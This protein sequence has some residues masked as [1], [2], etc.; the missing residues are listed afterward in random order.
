MKLFTLLLLLLACCSTRGTIPTSEEVDEQL[1]EKHKLYL[2]GSESFKDSSGFTFEHRGDSMLFSCLNGASGLEVEYWNAVLSD[3]RPLRH[4]LITPEDS[5]TSWSKDMM[6]GYLFCLYTDEDKNRAQ[7]L[8][9][10]TIEYGR[11]NLWNLCGD[12][13][14]YME[15]ALRKTEMSTTAFNVE[16]LSRCVMSP[17]LIYL[18]HKLSTKLGNDCNISCKAA[19]TVKFK[20]IVKNKGFQR[21]L[22]VLTILMVGL[23]ENGVT[24]RQLDSLRDSKASEPNNAL[25][26]AVYHKFYD[27]NFRKA[28]ELLRDPTLWPNT[29]LPTYSLNFCTE[30]LYQRDEVRVRDFVPVNGCITHI[31]P[32]TKNSVHECG[33]EDGKEYPRLTYNKDWMPCDKEGSKNPISWIFAYSVMSLK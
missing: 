29:R 30:Y 22:D 18:A 4:P 6:I 13:E 33:L 32:I 19:L 10:R 27:G 24:S 25:Y 16:Y 9:K 28:K 20:P 2:D 3:G 31:S 21:H 26:S 14:E 1:K 11:A 12:R 23:L 8:I 17:T 5:L 15:A 7:E